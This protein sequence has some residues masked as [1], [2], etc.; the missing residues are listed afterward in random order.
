MTVS[1]IARGLSQGYPATR[2][3]LR[4]AL[5][6]FPLIVSEPEVPE[7]RPR[8]PVVEEPRRGKALDEYIAE[9]REERLHRRRGSA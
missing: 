4:A 8:A 2:R 6:Q 3:A 1:R 5:Q 7:L 9:A